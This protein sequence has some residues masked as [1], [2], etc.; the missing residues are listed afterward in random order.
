MAVIVLI[1]GIIVIPNIIE[2]AKNGDI[3][4]DKVAT[5]DTKEGGEG[6]LAYINI[7]GED[8]KVPAFKLIDQNRDTIT[9]QS[10]KGKVFLVEFF[11]TR[12]PDIC[13]PMSKNLI[14]IQ[15]EF[16]D[17]DDFGIASITIDPEYDTPGILKKYAAA[18]GAVHPN[19][20]YLTGNRDVIYDLSNIG[21]NINVQA[22]PNLEASFTHSGLFA[23]VDQNGFIRS[24]YDK[25]GNPLVYY[26]GSIP[27]GDTAEG[28]ET[29]Q[30]DILIH[31]I[32]KLLKEE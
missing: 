6:E 2:R 27:R 5:L 10:Y 22:N 17:R 1:F 24:R 28:H 4:R 26:R 12:C 9:D 23:L 29:P 11:F 32:K 18:Y 13:I 25:Y 21:F 20:H 15:D 31:D 16:M 19:W 7:N 3:V 8:R 14:E 30:I